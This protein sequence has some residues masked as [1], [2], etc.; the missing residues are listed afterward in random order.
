M[1]TS[2]FFESFPVAGMLT[3]SSAKKFV[4]HLTLGLNFELEEKVDVMSFNPGGIATKLMK[5]ISGKDVN[6]DPGII[7]PELA[8]NT[9]FRDVGCNDYSNGATSHAIMAHILRNLPKMAWGSF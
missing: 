8:V 9:A 1:V 7:E 5:E 4:T 6:G 3:Y 2:T